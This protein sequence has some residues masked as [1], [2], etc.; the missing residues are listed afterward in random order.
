M[1]NHPD[2]RDSNMNTSNL[3]LVALLGA[4]L[5]L[6]SCGGGGGGG[7]NQ[8]FNPG[9]GTMITPPGGDGTGD[10][11]GPPAGHVD[12]PDT[13]AAARTITSGEPITGY[14]DGP[15]DV[16]YF[17][18]PLSEGINEIS[19][20]LDAPTGTEVT[21]MD[22]N[23]NVL[24]TGTTASTVVLEPGLYGG[25]EEAVVRVRKAVK[26]G[27][28]GATKYVLKARKVALIQYA[29]LTAGFR[30]LGG[31]LDVQGDFSANLREYAFCKAAN[32]QVKN[33]ELD[34]TASGKVDV[35]VKGITLGS[36]EVE[37]NILKVDLPPCVND[38]GGAT[39]T[40]KFSLKVTAYF[41]VKK[42]VQYIGGGSDTLEFEFEKEFHV[43]QCKN[44]SS[45]SGDG[46]GTG[47]GGGSNY[48]G[49]WG[50]HAVLRGAT[51]CPGR[52]SSGYSDA[53]SAERAVLSECNR[54]FGDCELID[55]A[56]QEGEFSG[57]L[58]IVDRRSPPCV[59]NSVTCEALGQ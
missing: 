36:W 47:E 26:S 14:L 4:L 11:D 38:D 33:C 29:A 24:A 48:I 10:D 25:L 18:L 28:R 42:I 21:V 31:E 53:A 32:K 40:E 12:E 3:K 46:S 22:Q 44:D 6:P 19:V 13:M 55:K 1:T 58:C 27:V 7:N 2:K 52:S 41:R 57:S 56:Y 15:D 51:L 30:A 49:T 23:G 45:G 43:P 35:K 34:I 37:N 5:V 39:F 54:L 59:V 16:D 20:E 50:A 9:P 8:D 17:R